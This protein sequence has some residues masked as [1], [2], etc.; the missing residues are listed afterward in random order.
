MTIH[1]S[2]LTDQWGYFSDNSLVQ[3]SCWVIKHGWLENPP[4]PWPFKWEIHGT[5]QRN[6]QHTMCDDH[7]WPLTDH[8]WL[9]FLNSCVVYC[10][11]F[12]FFNKWMGFL[13]VPI[14]WCHW[15]W[16]P[17]TWESTSGSRWTRWK[18]RATQK[19][20]FAKRGV[21]MDQEQLILCLKV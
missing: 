7:I 18:L 17:G 20:R 16:R 6:F 1:D 2:G 21:I 5:K 13:Y 8:L 10:D 12:S 15:K 3:A 19:W 14:G 9:I 11:V 4:F